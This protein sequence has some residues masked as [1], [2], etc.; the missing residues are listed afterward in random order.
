MSHTQTLGHLICDHTYLH[1]LKSGS[2]VQGF[3]IVA[4]LVTGHWRRLHRRWPRYGRRRRSRPR[5]RSRPGNPSLHFHRLELLLRLRQ[6]LFLSLTARKEPESASVA[7]PSLSAEVWIWTAEEVQLLWSDAV[8]FSTHHW[9]LQRWR[10]F[11]STPEL[12]LALIPFALSFAHEL[13]FAPRSSLLRSP[14]L[15][16]ALIPFAH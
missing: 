6:L 10:L 9:H 11:C 12:S 7:P 14:S 5:P 2:S 16:F 4:L 1:H 15:S 8:T 3:R 13:S